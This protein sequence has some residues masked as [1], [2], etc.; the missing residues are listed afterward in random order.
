MEIWKDVVGYEGLYQVSTNGRVRSV[1]RVNSYGRRQKERIRRPTLNKNGYLYVCL[2]RDSESKNKLV[3][4]MVAEAFIENPD[5]LRTVNHK[6]EVK[7][8]NRADNLEWMSLADNLRYGTHVERATKNKP[9]MHGAR[10][11]NYGRRGAGAQTHKGKVIATKVADPSVVIEFDTA[12]TAAR[13]LGINTGRL[14]ETLQ[15]KRKSYHGYYW[16][17]ED[18]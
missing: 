2:R 12:A 14:C 16:R 4:R 11:P 8:D 6:N 7:T 17:R 9:D 15:G 3:H 1:G 10:H 5:G 18:G 13:E